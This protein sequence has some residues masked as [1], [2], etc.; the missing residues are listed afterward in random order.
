MILD[1]NEIVAKLD[2]ETAIV[3]FLKKDGSTRVMMC[4]RNNLTAG[5][6]HG[7]L[8]GLLS[9]H[10]RR[11]NIGNGNIAA[12]DLVIGEC[13]AFNKARVL[14]IEWLGVV[15]DTG[16]LNDSFDKF[17]ALRDIKQQMRLTIDNI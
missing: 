9:A 14:D 6:N 10:D 5:F 12:I 16:T 17:L 7:Y 15:E 8:G 13:R 3:T 2:K 4:S 1:Y 11:C